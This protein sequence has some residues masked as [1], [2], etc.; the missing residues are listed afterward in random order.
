MKVTKSFI[1]GNR[2]LRFRLAENLATNKSKSIA[3]VLDWVEYCKD[4]HCSLDLRMKHREEPSVLVTDESVYDKDA[5][6]QDDNKK[7]FDLL[8][9]ADI[10]FDPE[11][12][13]YLVKT[14]VKLNFKTA[15]ISCTIRN[16]STFNVFLECLEEYGLYYELVQFENKERW[17]YYPEDLPIHIIK[18]I[19]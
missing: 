18:I 17:F 8:V 1:A 7:G 19:K 16:Q 4:L 5:F 11:I 13:P 6:N 9:G 15:F 14:M 12:I 10:V 3:K 2:E